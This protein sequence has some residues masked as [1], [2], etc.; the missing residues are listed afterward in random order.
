VWSA[1]IFELPPPERSA[2]ASEPMTAID[3]TPGAIGSVACALRSRTI[4]SRSI[5][6]AMAPWAAKSIGA[7]RQRSG[8]SKRPKR[9]IVRRMRCTSSS[10]G[11]LEIRPAATAAPS[12]RGS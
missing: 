3:R 2:V 8:W 11:A 5:S 9:N 6:R 7:G 10:I 1:V 12:A 4:A